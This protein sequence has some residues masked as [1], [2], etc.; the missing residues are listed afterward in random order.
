MIDSFTE[1]KVGPKAATVSEPTL[2]E[3]WQ[4]LGLKSTRGQGVNFVR[5]LKILWQDKILRDHFIYH[6]EL[7]TLP[8]LLNL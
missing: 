3:S 6:S 7:G 5:E 8:S 4:E 2:E 1:V